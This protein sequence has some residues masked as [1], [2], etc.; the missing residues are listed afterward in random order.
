MHPEGLGVSSLIRFAH[1]WLLPGLVP[2]CGTPPFEPLGPLQTNSH[3]MM[4]HRIPLPCAPGGTRTPNDGSEDRCDIHFTTGAC[5]HHTCT[6]VQ[7]QLTYLFSFLPSLVRVGRRFAISLFG[8]PRFSNVRF[9]H[10]LPPRG[11]KCFPD[12]LPVRFS[13]H[14]SENRM[15]EAIRFSLG[16]GRENRTPVST[17]ARSRHTTKLYPQLCAESIAQFFSYTTKASAYS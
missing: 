14:K 5:C 10:C 9:A 7:I 2:L 4:A 6:S 15:T 17:M 16:A 13:Y 1:K 8:N 3:A 11:N 12:P